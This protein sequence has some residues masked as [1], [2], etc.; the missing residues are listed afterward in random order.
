M[1]PPVRSKLPADTLEALAEQMEARK[2]ELGAPVLADKIDM[3]KEQLME[4][5][6]EQSVPGRSTMS[7]EE[8]AA[9]V[10]PPMVSG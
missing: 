10:A 7:H 3:T 5:A 9:T 1:F 6:Q 8:L 4:L 2:A